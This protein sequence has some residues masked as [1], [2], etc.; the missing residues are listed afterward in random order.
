MTK[1]IAI[2]L[3]LPSSA[4]SFL[5]LSC[6]AKPVAE[7]V[8]FSFTDLAVELPSGKDG[9]TVKIIKVDDELGYYAAVNRALHPIIEA[10]LQVLFVTSDHSFDSEC[11]VALQAGLNCDP[12]YGVAI[13]RTNLGGSAPVPRR[14]GEA[15]AQGPDAFNKFLEKLPEYSGGG[16]VQRTPVLVET[17]ILY[18]F[19]PLEGVKLD[20][21]DALAQLF[22]RANRRGYS[23]V[24][25]NRVLFY[26]RE[27]EPHPGMLAAPVLKQ[28]PDY[29][30][31]LGQHAEMPEQ[32]LEAFLW[33]HFR[34]KKQR[35]VL[36]D[37]RNLAAGYNGTAQHI[38][39]LLQPIC[40]QAEQFSI[41]PFFWVQPQSSQFH[42]LDKLVPGRLM[43]ELDKDAIFDASIR[44]SQPWSY[45]E[46][47]DLARC[48]PVNLYLILD[49]IAW[50]CYY[51]RMPHI[52]G[53]WRTAAASADGFVFLSRFTQ[54]TFQERF[55]AAR[56]VPSTIS[57][58]S[59]DPAE[60]FTSEEDLKW[61]A[62]AQGV[63]PYVLIVGNQYHHKGLKD[64]VR[65][66]A[67]SF[68]ETKIKV[69]GDVGEDYSNVEQVPS[70]M[71]SNEDIDRLF[72][73]CACLVFP[74]YYEGFGLPVLKALAFGKAVIARRSLL[75]DEINDHIKP[76]EGIVQ[77]ERKTG[78]LR[79]ISDVLA[80]KEHLNEQRQQELVPV[81]LFGWEQS[82]GRV[83]AFVDHSLFNADYRR[84]LERLEFF[85]RMDQFDIE[86]AG[87][88]NQNQNKVMFD[89][90]REG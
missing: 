71:I 1:K 31:A 41:T 44:L 35:Q 55:P 60:Y 7:I 78:L 30:K 17:E 42:S 40:R 68:P 38:L 5:R 61:E 19:G 64:V 50:D 57:Y 89:V 32:K 10:G 53:V 43:F 22:I 13:P 21:S 18:N 28:A 12:M 27:D 14:L 54:L 20:L 67:T 23:A 34:P 87:W 48:A 46:L 63:A 66:L 58:S 62:T 37:I 82:A 33:E 15:P 49:A 72:R 36:F 16:I 86:R 81:D 65:V 85:Y 9:P 2:F 83:L 39:S 88:L 75:I 26:T 90:G 47:K 74:S 70:G 77:F 3:L 69:I 84:C 51:V 73:Q 8:V 29:Y 25:C 59:L 24:V 79:A 6:L 52:D 45:S 80:R 76:V 4:E 56:A 11:V